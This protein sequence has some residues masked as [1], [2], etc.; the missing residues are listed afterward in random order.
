MAMPKERL[1]IGKKDLTAEYLNGKKF[2][3]ADLACEDIASVTIEPYKAGLFKNKPGERI[4]IVRCVPSEPII[5]Y[6][7]K[8]KNVF[9]GYVKEL[10]KF[11]TDNRVK[12]SRIKT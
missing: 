11:C 3:T 1:L 4:V 8:L 6:S 12:F 2:E 9:D 10:E 5:Y 7:E